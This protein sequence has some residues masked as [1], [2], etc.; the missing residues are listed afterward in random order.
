[1]TTRTLPMPS[2]SAGVDPFSNPALAALRGQMTS[3]AAFVQQQAAERS[4]AEQAVRA[5]RTWAA[6]QLSTLAALRASG[7][8]LPT[9]TSIAAEHPVRGLFR[10][11]LDAILAV[12]AGGDTLVKTYLALH[13][14][15]TPAAALAATTLTTALLRTP[16]SPRLRQTVWDLLPDLY[17]TEIPVALRR[18]IRLALGTTPAQAALLAQALTAIAAEYGTI[19]IAATPSDRGLAA[20]A[21]TDAAVVNARVAAAE[22]DAVR[23]HLIALYPTLAPDAQ[24]GVVAGL[25]VDPRN[26]EEGAWLRT[27]VLEAAAR[28]HVGYAVAAAGL[29]GLAHDLPL[30][31]SLLRIRFQ[32]DSSARAVRLAL[33][34]IR[35]GA[36]AFTGEELAVIARSTSRPVRDSVFALAK[37][38]APPSPAPDTAST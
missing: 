8:P 11:E 26:W 32:T 18:A 10:Q 12:P 7:S 14:G 27:Q 36:G 28:G 30:L 37:A 22:A 21:L 3:G 13:V 15:P 35:S 20:R 38:M 9:R 6:D 31:R 19:D 25:A 17:R 4:P 29:V 1:M 34:A 24:R 2:A 33:R 23:A 5:A 16:L